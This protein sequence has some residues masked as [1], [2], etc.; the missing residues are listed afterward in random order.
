MALSPSIF[1]DSLYTGLRIQD[2]FQELPSFLVG[3]FVV[4]FL[5]VA[6]HL[7]SFI[8]SPLFKSYETP[9]A[10]DEMS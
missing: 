4:V 6:P 1:E 5:A 9:I 2:K 3:F 8:H 7:L 10:Q